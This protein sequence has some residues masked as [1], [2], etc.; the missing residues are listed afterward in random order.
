MALREVT[1]N[2]KRSKA[3]FI[4]ILRE[5]ERLRCFSSSTG[6]YED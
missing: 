4:I 5:V 6:V 1:V 2:V 3:S